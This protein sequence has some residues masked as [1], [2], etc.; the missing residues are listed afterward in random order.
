MTAYG[1]TVARKTLDRGAQQ[2]AERVYLVTSARAAHS[3][4]MSGR[5]R[6]Y[7]ISMGVRVVCLTLA[8][9]VLTG[10]LRLIGI[11]AALI[12]PWVA[13]VM[14]NAGPVDGDEQPTFVDQTE[15]GIDA[16]PTASIDPGGG[17]GLGAGLDVGQDGQAPA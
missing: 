5:L 3:A 9:F 1:R 14:A 12:L 16:G 7:L 13:V 11:A 2:P 4:E 15:V 17:A 8:I 10:W 6:R